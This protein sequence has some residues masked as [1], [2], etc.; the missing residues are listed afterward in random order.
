ML[1]ICARGYRV[2]EHYDARDGENAVRVQG[3]DQRLQVG[4]F[5]RCALV[6]L[7]ERV[8][9]VKVQTELILDVDHER[10]D[11]GR[12]G[13]AD[14][15]AHLLRALRSEAIDVESADWR[16]GIR[17]KLSNLGRSGSRGQRRC[18]AAGGAGRSR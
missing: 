3:V 13:N 11:L 18:S 5:R 4:N 17:A 2:L 16:G 9:R 6:L 14:E 10:V 1:G 12:V 15:P 8:A 7:Q